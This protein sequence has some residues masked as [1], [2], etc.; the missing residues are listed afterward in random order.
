MKFKHV[1]LIG[2]GGTGS[3]LIGPLSQ[4]L[5]FHP[6][7]TNDITVIDGDIYENSNATRQVFDEKDLGANKAE[8]TAKRLNNPN[9]RT[10]PQFIDE[11]KFSRI[12]EKTVEK[13][14]NFLIIT[15]VDNHATRNAIIKALDAG[16][17]SNFVLISPGNSYDQ[18]QIILYVKEDGETKTAHPFVKYADLAEPVDAIPGADGCLNHINSA[19]QLITANMGAAWGTLLTVSNILDERGFYE[20]LHFNCRKTKMV[21]QGTLKGVLV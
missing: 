21:P 14:D 4:L 1:F 6:E 5:H 8:A 2:A 11:E 19:P 20:E 10:I 13:I 18:G 15:A 9:I 17:Y 3:H 7:G 12:L 16:N